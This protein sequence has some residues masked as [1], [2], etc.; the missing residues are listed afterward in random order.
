MRRLTGRLKVF[1]ATASL[2]VLAS[3]AVPSQSGGLGGVVGGVTGTAGGVVGGV[4]GSV[5]GVVGGA[6]GHTGGMVGGATNSM[7][8]QGLASNDT[9]PTTKNGILHSNKAL[10]KL[11]ANVLGIKAGV[12]VLDRYG[13]L[14]RINVRAADLL[15][16]K[17]NIYVLRG[18]SLVKVSAKVALAG[19]KVKG[20]VFVIDRHGTLLKGKVF[21]GLGGLKAKVG[22]KVDLK[23]V[24]VKV[25]ISLGGKKRP[26]T[27]GTPGTPGNPGNPNDPGN[28]N[29]PPGGI[30]DGIAALSVHERNQLKKRCI[31]VLSNPAA[32]NR[33]AVQVCRVLAQLAG[34]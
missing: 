13:N 5:G 17:A 27:P 18:G 14:I 23:P 15:K 30:D 7:T 19:L 26:G 11:R 1:T 21:V 34:L 6:T 4:T 24:S 8:S 10:V 9:S 33:D 3:M 31:S 16:A 22:A 20:K 29:N 25:G 28:P 12:Y 32:Y 2:I